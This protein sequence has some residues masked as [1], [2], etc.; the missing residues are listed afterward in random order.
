MKPESMVM[1]LSTKRHSLGAYA[2]AALFAATVLT[3]FSGGCAEGQEGDRC[4][5]LLSHDECGGDTLVCS[6]PSTNY[7]LPGTC[8]ENYCCPKDP[9]T[10]SNPECNGTD[11]QCPAAPDDSGTPAPDT[12]MDAAPE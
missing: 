4:N 3:A 8:V 5:P 1:S 10:S 12:G 6:G 9:K 11:T 7:P 2:V